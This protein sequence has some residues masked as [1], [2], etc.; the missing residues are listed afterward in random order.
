MGT[1]PIQNRNEKR[2]MC[3]VVDINISP[4]F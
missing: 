1:F 4:L 2:V 3:I